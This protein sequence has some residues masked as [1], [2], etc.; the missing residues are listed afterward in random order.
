MD[1]VEEYGKGVDSWCEC[2]HENL[3][4]MTEFEYFMSW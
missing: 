3:I 4:S 2:T 1:V